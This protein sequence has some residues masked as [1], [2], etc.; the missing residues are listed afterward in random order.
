MTRSIFR[1]FE[2]PLGSLRATGCNSAWPHNQRTWQK[3]H[4]NSRLSVC[5]LPTRA[6]PSDQSSRVKRSRTQI[7]CF[8]SRGGM[9]L[10][11]NYA[12]AL[13]KLMVKRRVA[14]VRHKRTMQIRTPSESGLAS[15]IHVIVCMRGLW[16]SIYGNCCL[17]NDL[18]RSSVPLANLAIFHSV[19]VKVSHFSHCFLLNLHL[20][21]GLKCY[22]AEWPLH[23][24]LNDTSHLSPNFWNLRSASLFAFKALKI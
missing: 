4:W 20:S 3:T 19:P 14:L 10:P 1:P 12:L 9:G 5:P 2:E 16:T 11:Q 18:F 15:S 6:L 17:L 8:L 22:D 13:H 23:S 21:W 7:Y 24:I